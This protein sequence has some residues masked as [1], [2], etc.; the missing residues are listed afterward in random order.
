MSA[1]SA[2]SKVFPLR[3]IFASGLG[4]VR[5]SKAGRRRRLIVPLAPS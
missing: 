3:G 2:L 5:E 4:R 1:A